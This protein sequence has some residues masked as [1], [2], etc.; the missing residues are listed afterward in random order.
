MRTVED[1]AFLLLIVAVSLAFIWL[2]WPFYGAVLWGTVTAI[3]FA[4]LCRRLTE[5]MG[6]RRNLAA[7]ATVVIIVAIV[8]LPLSLIG[9]SLI[10][11][12]SG[13]YKR[14]QAG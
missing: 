8:I 1:K 2:V 9:M 12:A 3:M 10:Q 11:E 13:V 5:A 6:R 7:L 14:M 4:P